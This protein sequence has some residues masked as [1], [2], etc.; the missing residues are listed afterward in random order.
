MSSA[1]YNIKDDP[2][3]ERN[4]YTVP[5]EIV[6]RL[7]SSLREFLTSINAPR[8]QHIRLGLEDEVPP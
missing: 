8:E 5:P 1:R 6:E 3:Q 7:K 4:R 2:Q